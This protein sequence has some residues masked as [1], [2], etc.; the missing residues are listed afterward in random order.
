M[1]NDIKMLFW[2]K[3]AFSLVWCKV[4]GGRMNVNVK[5]VYKP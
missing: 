3:E 5:V 4:S 2:R 1:R